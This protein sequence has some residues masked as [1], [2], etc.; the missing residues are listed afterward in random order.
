MQL[1]LS[2]SLSFL[3]GYT[4]LNGTLKSSQT[5]AQK[6]SHRCWEKTWHKA[7]STILTGGYGRHSESSI[8][9]LDGKVAWSDPLIQWEVTTKMIQGLVPGEEKHSTHFMRF[10]W[11]K[12]QQ[13]NG[14]FPL[15]F[16]RTKISRPQEKRQEPHRTFRPCPWTSKVSGFKCQPQA[17]F[18]SRHLTGIPLCVNLRT[19]DFLFFL[20][21]PPSISR[22]TLR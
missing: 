8:C 15:N 7:E 10:T 22:H 21:P 12:H 5:C 14:C 2:K 19:L 1:L 13:S 16:M 17:V 4:I 11:V 3:S 20:R 6:R 9:C 18:S